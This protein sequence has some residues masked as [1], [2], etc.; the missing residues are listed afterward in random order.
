MLVKEI[1]AEIF[2]VSFFCVLFEVLPAKI[3]T[4]LISA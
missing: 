3:F 2:A 4:I 1:V